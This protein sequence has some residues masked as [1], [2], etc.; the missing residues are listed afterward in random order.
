MITILN[1]CHLTATEK[2]ALEIM[3]DSGMISAYNKVRTKAYEIIKGTP[4]KDNWIYDV[5][6]LT[7]SKWFV[8]DAAKWRTKNIQIKHI[9]TK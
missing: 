4:D 2:R 1:D 7:K 6:I 8:G 5:K 3:I 9:K